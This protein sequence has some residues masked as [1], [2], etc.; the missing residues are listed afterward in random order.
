MQVAGCRIQDTGCMI[1]DTKKQGA[2]GKE[3]IVC[4]IVFLV[5]YNSSFAPLKSRETMTAVIL[6]EV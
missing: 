3:Q 6:F 4:L 2:Y 1:L 5:T